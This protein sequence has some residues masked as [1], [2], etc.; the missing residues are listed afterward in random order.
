MTISRKDFLDKTTHLGLLLTTSQLLQYCSSLPD[1]YADTSPFDQENLSPLWKSIY[2]GIGAPNPHNTQAWKIK[3]LNENEILL[4][5]D[6]SRILLDT[7][8]PARQIHIGQGSFIEC[9]SIGAAQLGYTT[10]VQYFPQ[11]EYKTS[12]IGKKPVAKLTLS[13][14]DSNKKKFFK[15]LN[16]RNTNRSIYSGDFSETDRDKIQNEIQ[17]DK[18]N[19]KWILSSDSRFA[20]IQDLLVEAFAIETNLKRTN[21]ENRIWF[22]VTDKEIYSKRDGISLRGNGMS[23]LSYKIIS[24]FFVST[25]PE[26]WHSDFTRKAGIDSFKEQV[27]SSKAFIYIL[28]S[29][30]EMKDWVESG[31]KYAHLNIAVNSLSYSMHP[32]SQFLQEYPEMEKVKLEFEKLMEIP[33]KAKIQMFARIGKSD[34]FFQSPRRNPQDMIVK[35]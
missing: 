19:F 18:S 20:K 28:T 12:E 16:I 9:F 22:R 29:K 11:G 3:I 6:E 23:G 8:P 34:Y 13:A 27:K 14:G 21:E 31:E 4:F 15:S 30:N 17:Y 2:A 32:M 35:S 25:K 24:N 5:V 7:D 26:D 1:R 33:P 10:K